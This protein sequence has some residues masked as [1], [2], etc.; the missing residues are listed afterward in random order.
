MSSQEL[1]KTTQSYFSSIYDFIK[2]NSTIILL[3]V[4][5]YIFYQHLQIK[6]KTTDTSDENIGHFRQK[7]VL[8]KEIDPYTRDSRILKK[9]LQ[10][11]S[12][13]TR[14][15]DSDIY[16][17]NISLLKTEIYDKIAFSLKKQN[18]LFYIQL[19]SFSTIRSLF[20]T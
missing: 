4:G 5:V 13:N 17:D 2:K 7:T 19:K 12:K 18:P 20:E 1:E 10:E 16:D 3:V 11:F 6:L 9:Q 14:P 15:Y 8:K